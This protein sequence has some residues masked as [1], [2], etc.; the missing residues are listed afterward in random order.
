MSA[1]GQ[2]RT[3]Q[4][5]L[6]MSALPPKAAIGTQPRNV[7]FVPKA[8]MTTG[9]HNVCFWRSEADISQRLVDVRYSP[10]GGHSRARLIG[11]DRDALPSFA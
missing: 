1:L 6:V 8:D 5:I 4:C 7:R 9:L 10:E 11:A 2:K 3:S